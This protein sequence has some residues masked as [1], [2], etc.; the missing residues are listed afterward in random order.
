M[1]KPTLAHMEATLRKRERQAWHKLQSLNKAREE[2]ENGPYDRFMELVEARG[3]AGQAWIV[4]SDKLR[5]FRRK[6]SAIPAIV[7]TLESCM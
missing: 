5:D 1:K 4:A 3:R 7:K 2:A 6:N